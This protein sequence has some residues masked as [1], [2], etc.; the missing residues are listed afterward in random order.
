M[1]KSNVAIEELEIDELMSLRDK[2]E[3][4]IKSMAK[5]RRAKL[6][7]EMEAL[8]PYLKVGKNG[9]TSGSKVP[10]KY[11]DP[12]SGQT[13]SGRGRPPAWVLAHEQNGG[14]RDELLID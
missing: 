14:K 6:R 11:K 8:E 2:V 4:R 7:A 3:D 13:W 1:A 10:P 9:T 12:I 5:A